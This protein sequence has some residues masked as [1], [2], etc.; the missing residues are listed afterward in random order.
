MVSSVERAVFGF[1]DQL[2]TL[3]QI[4]IDYTLPGIRPSQ[5]HLKTVFS[6]HKQMPQWNNGSCEHLLLCREQQD[7]PS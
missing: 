6:N 2:Q 3:Q 4:N 1:V 7:L 5:A